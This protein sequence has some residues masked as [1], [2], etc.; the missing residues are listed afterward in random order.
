MKLLI[1]VVND[2]ALERLLVNLKVVHVCMALALALR[3]TLAAAHRSEVL[4]FVFEFF[5]T[6]GLMDGRRA[7]RCD[8]VRTVDGRR[9]VINVFVTVAVKAG[10][11]RT[12]CRRG[13]VPVLR[14]AGLDDV[15]GHVLRVQFEEVLRDEARRN[16]SVVTL[17]KY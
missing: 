17:Y 1:V 2:D 7:R 13:R 9:A 12:R 6:N 11:V 15:I 3:G 14:L 5:R 10:V 4:L 16:P 8:E